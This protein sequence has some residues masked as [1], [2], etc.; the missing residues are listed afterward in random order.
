MSRKDIPNP[1]HVVGRVLGIFLS[2][3]S[4]SPVVCPASFMFCASLCVCAMGR[5]VLRRLCFVCRC[6]C[7][8]WVVL[9]CVVYVLCIV[10]CVRHG[11]LC[12]RYPKRTN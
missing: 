7:V 12:S 11:S 9:S 2:F 3:P 6:V 10:V 8:P 4:S 1:I 5:F